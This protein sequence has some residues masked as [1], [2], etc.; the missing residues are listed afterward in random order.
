MS[1]AISLFLSL[2]IIQ[3]N[4]SLEGRSVEFVKSYFSRKNVA[5]KMDTTW[6]SKIGPQQVVSMYIGLH[7]NTIWWTEC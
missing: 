4:N 1:I 2:A 3:E 5:I 6:N 7:L